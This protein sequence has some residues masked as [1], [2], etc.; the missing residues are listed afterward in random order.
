[1]VA[2]DAGSRSCAD[3]DLG[4]KMGSPVTF[5]STAQRGNDSPACAGS[6]NDVTFRWVAPSAGRYRID[7]CGSTFDTVLVLRRGTCTGPLID[8][9]DDSAECDRN[10]ILM[11]TLAA[12]EEVVIVVDG[13]GSSGFFLLNIALAP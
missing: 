10:A 2:S 6:G 11:E 9:E 7:T 1:V 4:S 12:G 5:G 8:C 13:F 3:E